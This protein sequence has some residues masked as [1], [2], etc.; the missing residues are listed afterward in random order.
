MTSKPLVRRTLAT[1]RKAEFGFFGVVVYTR[2]H[3]PRFCGH[4]SRWRAFSRYTFGS[5][6]LRI[7]WLM[8]GIVRPSKSV[9]ASLTA[10]PAFVPRDGST[11]NETA[12]ASLFGDASATPTE[13]RRAY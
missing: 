11:Q 12:P 2:V 3:T 4:A 9:G 1:L 5:R 10:A 6:G 7:S 8:V 13:D